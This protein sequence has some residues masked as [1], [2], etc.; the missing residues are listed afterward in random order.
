[1]SKIRKE[2]L[3]ACEFRGHK[4]ANWGFTVK[5][6]GSGIRGG[7]SF[8]VVRGLSALPQLS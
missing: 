2:A 8:L 4:M 1:M 6:G 3:A 5:A 7:R